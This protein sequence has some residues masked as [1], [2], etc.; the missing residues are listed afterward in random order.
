[1]SFTSEYYKKTRYDKM[2]EKMRRINRTEREIKKQIKDVTNNLELI[3]LGVKNGDKKSRNELLTEKF[4]IAN[5]RNAKTDFVKQ[6][7]ETL[8]ALEELKSKLTPQYNQVKKEASEFFKK[9]F[10]FTSKEIIDEFNW[11]CQSRYNKKPVVRMDTST[12]IYHN[13]QKTKKNLND[14]KAE[15]A[16]HNGENY[17]FEND[18][19]LGY[20][21]YFQ[22]YM[23]EFHFI[24]L[25]PL[26]FN[27]KMTD[28]TTLEENLKTAL[29]DKETE[30]KVE[31]SSFGKFIVPLDYT[32]IADD[33][34]NVISEVM[35]RL[36]WKV[37][38]REIARDKK[39][40]LEEEKEMDF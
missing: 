7:N 32:K 9:Y 5:L 6:L 20:K 26:D 38:D 31:R 33:E 16:K 15:V 37:Y 22:I 24:Y 17:D 40:K 14:F 3:G 11:V 35:T 39:A 23:Q 27:M 2:L 30:L 13:G 12:Y 8:E 36:L 29:H 34:N 10:V 18:F 19:G 25:L 4:V 28:N 1:M 21:L